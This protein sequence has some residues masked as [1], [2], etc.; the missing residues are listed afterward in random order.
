MNFIVNLITTINLKNSPTIY[1]SVILLKTNY[2]FG[3]FSLHSHTYL[4]F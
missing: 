4:S 2:Q 3:L 1:Q